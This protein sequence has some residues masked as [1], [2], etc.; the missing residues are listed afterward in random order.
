MPRAAAVAAA[1]GIPDLLQL[2]VKLTQSLMADR[3]MFVDNLEVRWW[4]GWVGGGGAERGWG[5]PPAG[6]IILRLSALSRQSS[7]LTTLLSCCFTPTHTAP[8]HS[9]CPRPHCCRLP[10]STVLEVKQIEGLGTTIDVVLVN[11]MLREGDTIVVCGLGGPIVTTIRALLTPQPL[12]VSCACGVVDRL[13]EM[14][15]R[16]V[17]VA[18]GNCDFAVAALCRLL[19]YLVMPP[20]PLA[21]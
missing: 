9:H 4:V 5:Q 11:G 13:A 17:G 15:A 7:Q 20:H 8:C 18:G 6:P 1:A 12:R 14:W 3:L 16:G 10:Q 2:V 21:R 19:S